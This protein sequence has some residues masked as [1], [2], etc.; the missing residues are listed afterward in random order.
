[1]MGTINCTYETSCGWC[2]KWDKKCDRKIGCNKDRDL[3][4]IKAG[5]GLAYSDVRKL[6]KE[7]WRSD[8][9]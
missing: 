5:H 8:V 7:P 9:P 3:E 1:M 2:I 6:F 4:N